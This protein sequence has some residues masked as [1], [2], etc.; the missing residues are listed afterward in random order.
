M[1]RITIGAEFDLILFRETF[2]CLKVTFAQ[3][4]HTFLFGSFRQNC[5]LIMPCFP[6]KLKP[7]KPLA[8]TW[9]ASWIC[10]PRDSLK[11]EHTCYKP[12][13]KKN[14]ERLNKEA[15]ATFRKKFLERDGSAIQETPETDQNSL[16]SRA[17]T[18][19]VTE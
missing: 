16:A 7:F 3:Q 6:E 15:I 11:C 12:E 14:F 4:S 5:T 18:T 8:Y 9:S 10:R 19:L 13:K 17:Q 2:N 1:N